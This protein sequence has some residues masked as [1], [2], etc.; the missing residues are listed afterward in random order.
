GWSADYLDPKNFLFTLLSTNTSMN[1]GDYRSQTF[2]ALMHDSDIE[3]D[4]KLRAELLAQAEQHMLNDLA[5]TPVYFGVTRNLVSTDVRDWIAN[6]V[7]INRT[8]WLWLRRARA[9]A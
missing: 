6:S 4:P 1:N 5:L 7:N 2:D 3:R 9:S 8:R